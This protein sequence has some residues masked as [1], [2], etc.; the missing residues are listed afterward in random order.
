MANI[1]EQIKSL[2]LKGE[3]VPKD[4]IIELFENRK[5]N[6]RSLIFDF[7]LK[8]NLKIY[9]HKN[10]NFKEYFMNKF[11]EYKDLDFEN[12]LNLLE[13]YKNKSKKYAK[14]LKIMFINYSNILLAFFS[15]I[16]YILFFDSNI[17]GKQLYNPEYTQDH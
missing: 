17:L 13:K 7:I 10:E 9:F 16:T 12:K 2:F 8:K 11:D 1:E 5:K 4:L 3:V 6:I 15:Y 14:M